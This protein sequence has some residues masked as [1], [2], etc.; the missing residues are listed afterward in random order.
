MVRVRILAAAVAAGLG[1]VLA[2]QA[3]AAEGGGELPKE[4]WSFS[5]PFG[6]F[7]RTQLQ[8]G[9]QV[10]SQVCSACHSM[11]LLY[12]RNLMDIGLSEAQVKEIAAG[13]EV[14]DGPNDEG[15]MFTRPGRPSDH[16]H[17][18]FANDNAAR[19][20]NNGALPP[21]LSLIIKARE[22][23]AN[24][25]YG[26]LTGFADPPAGVTVPE[27]M[28]YNKAFPG[29]MIAMPPPLSEGLVDY[30]GEPKA[31]VEQMA[32]DVTAFLA[33]ASEPE[34]EARKRLGIK[35]MLFLIIFTGMLYAVKRK[36]WSNV[37]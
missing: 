36:V 16:F 10:Y 12:Y 1:L 24:Y 14:N 25:V 13:V 29:H 26:V 9:W 3:G 22:G 21:D 33:W 2:A 34:M 8:R 27:N 11:H 23:G 31:T 5:G 37:H 19:A 18:P 4:N 20:A 28:H 17:S 32:K 35:V 30:G 6:T 7:D 15:E